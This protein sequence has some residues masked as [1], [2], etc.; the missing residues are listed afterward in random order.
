MVSQGWRH[1][2]KYPKMKR[3]SDQL[4][5][6]WSRRAG[7]IQ[8]MIGRW[9]KLQIV[10]WPKRRGKFR[11]GSRST[12]VGHTGAEA[13]KMRRSRENRSKTSGILIRID[14]NWVRQPV[15]KSIG[16]TEAKE[17][18]TVANARPAR[19]SE[20]EIELQAT[21]TEDKQAHLK[22]VRSSWR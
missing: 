2:G 7:K 21:T 17:R 16:M 9:R 18:Q 8:I 13:V 19:R 22:P 12:S 11:S 20:A 1:D 3:L 10:R 15:D 6:F 14:S 4:T 5:P